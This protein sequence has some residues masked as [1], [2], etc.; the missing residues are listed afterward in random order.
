MDEQDAA[1]SNTLSKGSHLNERRLKEKKVTLEEENEL[2]AEDSD[3]LMSQ[4]SPKL[5]QLKHNSHEIKHQTN[6]RPEFLSCQ[7]SD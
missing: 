5:R 2:Q 3:G 4:L 1:N 6:R 7:E